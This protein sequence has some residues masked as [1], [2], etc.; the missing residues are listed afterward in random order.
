MYEND[1]LRQICVSWT[2]QKFRVKYRAALITSDI[3]RDVTGKIAFIPESVEIPNILVNVRGSGSYSYGAKTTQPPLDLS[4]IQC[5]I[6]A[7]R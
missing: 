6:D 3:V 1:N 5:I 7:T 4:E 2:H